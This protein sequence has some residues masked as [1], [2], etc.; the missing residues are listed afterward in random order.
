LDKDN[1][2]NSGET[3][4]LN[5]GML[6]LGAGALYLLTKNSSAAS[7][8]GAPAPGYYQ[9]PAPTASP[10]PTEQKQ[11]EIIL[12]PTQ[13]QQL[14]NSP[15]GSSQG[16]MGMTLFYDALQQG[17]MVEA[18]RAQGQIALASGATT[19]LYTERKE[20]GGTIYTGPAPSGPIDYQGNPI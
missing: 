6:L 9:S 14:F 2:L 11:E 5:L 17:N 10:N 12:T 4:K 15:S 3:M 8:G 7:S 20:G 1:Y 19:A 16:E 18:A 13:R